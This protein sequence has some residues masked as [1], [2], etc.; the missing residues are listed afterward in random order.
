MAS[1]HHIDPRPTARIVSAIPTPKHCHKC[2][3]HH[4]RH[5]SPEYAQH[6]S[7]SL[8]CPAYREAPYLRKELRVD[9]DTHGRAMGCKEEVVEAHRRLGCFGMSICILRAY[10]RGPNEAGCGQSVAP[11]AEDI[12][13]G[14]ING[15]PDGRLAKVIGN[16]LWVERR[17]PCIAKSASASFTNMRKA[18]C[19]QR[20]DTYQLRKYSHPSTRD[21]AFANASSSVSV[22]FSRGRRRKCGGRERLQNKIIRAQQVC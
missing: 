22:I 15:E 11:E 10:R 21:I 1:T 12:Q 7:T 16:G 9:D 14:E 17:T 4:S 8:L 19:H 6:G 18:R 5:E 20:A 3:N 2:H 13:G